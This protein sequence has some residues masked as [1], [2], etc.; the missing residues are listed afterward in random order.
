MFDFVLF[1]WELLLSIFSVA[2][3]NPWVNILGRIV[4]YLLKKIFDDN[5][6]KN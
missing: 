5:D 1:L 3:D 4:V 6:P 2:I